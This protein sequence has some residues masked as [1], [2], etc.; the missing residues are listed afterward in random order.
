MIDILANYGPDI[1]NG[2]MWT[3]IIVGLGFVT[4]SLFGTIIGLA[5]NNRWTAIR[6]LSGTYIEIFRNTPLLVQASLLFACAGVMRI[7]V[8]PELIGVLC[9][10]L[11][12]AAY[13]AEIVRGALHSVPQSQWEASKALGLHKVQTFRLVIFPQ[14]LPYGLPASANLLATVTKESAFLSALSVAELT[15][16]GQVV[17]AQTFAVFEVWAIIGV[18]YLALVLS[19]L[20]IAARIETAFDWHARDRKRQ[21][22]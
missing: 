14:L 21:D 5:R 1:L 9:V 15:F 2:L 13:M 6:W 7:R 16:S 17:I 11:Y 12:T 8:D 4:G 10:A 19:L 22:V 18:L 20:A 3:I